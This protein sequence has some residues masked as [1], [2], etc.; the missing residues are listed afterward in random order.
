VTTTDASA[1]RAPLGVCRNAF[2]PALT[3]SQVIRATGEMGLDAL[4]LHSIFDLD[5]DLD[6]GRLAHLRAEARAVG[7]ELSAGLPALHPA[8]F[9]ADADL[10]R[11]GKGDASVG[12]VRALEALQVLGSTTVPFTIGV[13]EDRLAS[14]VPWTDQLDSTV[15]LLSL[16]AP[17]VREVGLRLCVKTHEEIT[18]FELL[19]LVERVGDDVLT[20]GF[21]PVNSLLRME[22]PL[23]ATTRLG[24]SIEHVYL[25]DAE[26][27]FEGRSIRRWLCPLGEGVLDWPTM[28]KTIAQSAPNARRFIDLHKGQ[29]LMHPLDPSWLAAQPDLTVS[30]LISVVGLAAAG[31]QRLSEADRARLTAA[32]S[33]PWDRL[34]QAISA[35]R[36]LEMAEA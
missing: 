31:D 12:F 5:R 10:I 30:E 20:V 33:T 8:R 15:S 24:P 34:V 7:V 25:E 19:R 3:P 26:L 14:D 6:S 36:E 17:A 28:R 21:D 18:T 1:T 35:A 2:E 29:F 16:L 13:V 27:G 23:A 22:D 11:V 4:L 9:T 32:Q